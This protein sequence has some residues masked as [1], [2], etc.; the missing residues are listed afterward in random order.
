MP[1]EPSA[2]PEW[3]VSE[4]ELA[5][6]FDQ[7]ADISGLEDVGPGPYVTIMTCEGQHGCTASLARSCEIRR[8]S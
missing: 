8:A 1:S 7:P 4:L 2:L 6:S 5:R 3:R